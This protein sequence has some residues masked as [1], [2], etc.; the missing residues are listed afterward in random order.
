MKKVVFSKR[1]T[2]M[3]F[4]IVVFFSIAIPAA[5]RIV[6]TDMM[7]LLLVCSDA[8]IFDD[9]IARAVGLLF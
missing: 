5:A 9:D 4:P 2:D 3:A 8:I 6:S 1:L 7:K